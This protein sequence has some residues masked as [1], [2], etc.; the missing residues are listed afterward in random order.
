MQTKTETRRYRHGD[1]ILEV[2]PGVRWFTYQ[3]GSRIGGGV[4]PFQPKQLPVRD[5]REQ[6]QKDLDTWADVKDL[7]EVE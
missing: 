4:L 6:A 7:E 3:T 5:S 2:V 1:R